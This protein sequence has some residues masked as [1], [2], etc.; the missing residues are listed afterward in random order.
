MLRNATIATLGLLGWLVSYA[1][2][3]DWLVANGGDFFGGWVEAFTASGFGTGLLSD[4][5]AVTLMCMAVAWW[6][7]RRIGGRWAL[8]MVASLGLSVSVSLA[9]YLLRSWML[10]GERGHAASRLEQSPAPVPPAG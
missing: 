4:L 6:E 10:R 5:V 1:F 9:I 3:F 8:A 7:R 2:F